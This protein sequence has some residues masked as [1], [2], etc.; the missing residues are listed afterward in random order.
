LAV[1]EQE[2]NAVS[3]YPNPAREYVTI[4]ADK[5]IQSLDI[6]DAYG[7]IVYTQTNLGNVHTI[8]TSL[9]AKGMYHLHLNGL[10]SQRLIVE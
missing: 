6:Y 7:R 3:I 4:T 2:A 8:D 10:E 1:S 9:L 5:S